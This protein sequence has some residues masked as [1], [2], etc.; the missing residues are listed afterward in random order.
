[1]PPL[2]DIPTTWSSDDSMIAAV[3]LVLASVEPDRYAAITYTTLVLY[4]LYSATFYTLALCRSRLMQSTRSWAHWVDTSWYTLLSA[5]SSGTN[6]LFFFGLY[7]SI[8]VASFR[9]GFGVGL[10]VTLTATVL[11][12]VIG[13]K[14]VAC[15]MRTERSGLQYRRA[16]SARYTDCVPMSF[17]LI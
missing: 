3:R 16:H 15:A 14:S 17:G 7:F 4:V 6:S 13:L 12:T 10:W 8:L 1:M 5:L 11:F 9:W 2:V